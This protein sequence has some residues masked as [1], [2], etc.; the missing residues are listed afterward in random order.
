MVNA[1]QTSSFSVNL[2][3]AQVLLVVGD[4]IWVF[5]QC[6][7]LVMLMMLL[8]LFVVNDDVVVVVCCLLVVVL[9]MPL[10]YNGAADT[11][12]YSEVERLT[13]DETSGA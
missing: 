1:T 9:V 7:Q 10:P 13:P 11:G 8:L 6:K 4:A 5:G 3:S 12:D 2:S